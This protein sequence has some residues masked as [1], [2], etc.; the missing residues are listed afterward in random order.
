MR[1][2]GGVRPTLVEENMPA[3]LMIPFQYPIGMRL[4]DATSLEV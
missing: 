3:L 1:S 4:H 2:I